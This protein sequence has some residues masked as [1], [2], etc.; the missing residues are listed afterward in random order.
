MENDHTN[1]Q[2]AHNQLRPNL[3]LTGFYQSSGLGGNQYNLTTGKLVS[4][5]DNVAI[6][7]DLDARRSIPIPASMRG[8]FESRHVPEFA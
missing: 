4:L 5:N 7:L 8:Q 3:S 1:I 6:A 2:L